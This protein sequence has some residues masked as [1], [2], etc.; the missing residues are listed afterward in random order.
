MYLSTKIISLSSPSKE[1]FQETKNCLHSRRMQPPRLV[2]NIIISVFVNCFTRLETS[3]KHYV[4]ISCS[5]SRKWNEAAAILGLLCSAQGQ[6]TKLLPHTK[7]MQLKFDQKIA[8]SY[9]SASYALL[10][11]I[12][13]VFSFHSY[14]IHFL[15]TASVINGIFH[16]QRDVIFCMCKRRRACS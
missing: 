6:W 11:R 7:S 8:A 2:G 9:N 15:W 1:Q 16:R 10:T 4:T 12:V 13:P 5:Q 14:I 3:I